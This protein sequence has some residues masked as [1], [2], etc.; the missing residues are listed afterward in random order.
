[1]FLGHR[2]LFPE[3][4]IRPV[5]FDATVL[6]FNTFSKPKHTCNPRSHARERHCTVGSLLPLDAGK[7]NPTQCEAVT[8]VAAQVMGN[9]VAV[10]VGGSNGHFELNV[11]KPLMV[12]NVLRSVRLLADSSVSF[13]DNCVVGIV[14]NRRVG[15]VGSF[16]ARGRRSDG[17]PGGAVLWAKI[18]FFFV[19]ELGALKKPEE[20]KV[21]QSFTIFVQRLCILALI[22]Q[23][24][25][26]KLSFTSA[27][28][29]SCG[30]FGPK[31]PNKYRSEA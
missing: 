17:I 28:W 31:L 22:C 11:F 18:C 21:V 9:H 1:M 12:S 6:A 4:K 27:V 20:A 5:S 10:T 3:L 2:C 8:M 29:F 24:Q 23:K 30:S 14:P 26:P 16:G 25:M 13:T 15:H 7:V 19:W